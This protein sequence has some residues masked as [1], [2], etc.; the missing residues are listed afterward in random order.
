MTALNPSEALLVLAIGACAY[1]A[2]LRIWIGWR[3]DG[4][5][6]WASAWALTAT[7]FAIARLAELNTPSASG[8]VLA[9]RIQVA[10]IPWFLLTLC[11]LVG[12]MS[13]W[14][15]H[16]T[17][18]R[19]WFG[20]SA[21]SSAAMLLSPWFISAAVTPARDLSG[22]LY[23]RAIGG[24]ALALVPLAMTAALVWCVRR[25]RES[26]ELGGR[27][28]RLAAFA[29][30]AYA[31]MGL[32]SL[33]GALRWLRF[34]GLA[35]YGPLVVALVAARMIA[36]RQQRLE[37]R[38]QQQVSERTDALRES[39]TRYRHVVEA[40]PVGMLS[41]DARGQLEHANGALLTLLGSTH[42]EFS[43]SFNVAHEANAQRSGFSAMLQRTLATG[44]ALS[45]E[46][47]FDTWWGRRI[48]THTLV[49]PYHD[50]SGAVAGALAIVEDITERRAIERRLGQAQ[51]MEA[52]GQLSAGIAHEINNP[53]AYVRSNLSVLGE[54]LSALA[55]EIAARDPGAPQLPRIATL[56]ALLAPSLASVERTIGIVRDLR[57]FSR[58]GS[59]ERERVDIGALLDNAAR[60]VSTRGDGVAE[61]ALECAETAPVLVAPGQLRL[62]LLNLLLNALHAAG[63]SGQVHASTANVGDEVFISVH[64]DGEAIAPE[65]RARLFEPLAPARGAGESSLGLYISRQIVHEHGGRIEVLSGGHHGTTFVV[66]LPAASAEAAE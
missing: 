37:E 46:F 62:V 61:V 16:P 42:S 40:A 15:S 14:R 8:A 20:F 44:E 51:R 60:L 1:L 34:P 28:K 64:D 52:V 19:R 66:R 31:A 17:R 54:E 59:A 43:S 49:A 58:A 48:A 30:A 6:H 63:A 4:P 18:A 11:R 33:L 13:G 57:E 55:K 5:I 7:V 41:I 32:L 27:E 3:A 39:E 23:L 26:R 10:C 45:E 65:E 2:S 24:W 50:E 35:E 25:L 38:L 21:L 36:A 53:M 47:E 29:L 9:A 22:G 12:S 56:E